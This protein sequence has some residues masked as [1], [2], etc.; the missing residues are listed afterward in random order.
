MINKGLVSCL[1]CFILEREGGVLKKNG[2]GNGGNW[3]YVYK[4]M[5]LWV[6]ILLQNAIKI[7]KKG[8]SGSL[9]GKPNCGWLFGSK[10]Y[11]GFQITNNNQQKKKKK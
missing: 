1:V 6:R 10:T 8:C 4:G 9:L 3:I 7:N 2:N 11:M 5:I